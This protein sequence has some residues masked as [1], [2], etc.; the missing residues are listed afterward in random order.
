[1]GENHPLYATGLN[2]LAELNESLGNYAKAEL[3]F[4]HTLEIR[5][6]VLGEKSPDYATS[7]NNLAMLYRGSVSTQRPC[8]YSTKPWKS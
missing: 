2:N 6:R 7:L 1:M 8:R 4:R 3:L 5:K